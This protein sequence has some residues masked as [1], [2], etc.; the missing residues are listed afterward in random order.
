M[1]VDGGACSSGVES[2]VLDAV[3][4]IGSGRCQSSSSSSSTTTTTSSTWPT[5]VILRPG[6]VT[7][8]MIQSVPGFE[9][10]AVYKRDF[11]DAALEAAPS[12]PGMKVKK[13]VR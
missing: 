5:P 6:G 9:G 11:V 3:T 10:V 2:T 7:V 4:S 1:I 12:T 8:E 13:P